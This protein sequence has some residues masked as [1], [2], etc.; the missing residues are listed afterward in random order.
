MKVGM[1]VNL[2]SYGAGLPSDAKERYI[3]KILLINNIDPF[4]GVF[5]GAEATS[6]LPP[7]DI[8]NLLL[9]LVLKTS[10]ITVSQFKGR[11]SLEAYNQFVCGW[12]KDV[13]T[14]KIAEKYLTTGR[15]SF[16]SVLLLLH[17][18]Y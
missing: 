13:A 15:V 4:L 11:K 8:S 12:V 16:Y 3:Q 2:S 1:A 18:W 7:V 6:D 9:Y 5:P 10:F 14:R 17:A